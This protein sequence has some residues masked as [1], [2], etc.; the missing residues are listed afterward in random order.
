MFIA[1]GEVV[2]FDPKRWQFGF[3][4]GASVK[5]AVKLPARKCVGC[6]QRSNRIIMDVE[7]VIDAFYFTSMST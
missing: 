1:R 7:Y 4:G 6:L 5:D 3:N 2:V